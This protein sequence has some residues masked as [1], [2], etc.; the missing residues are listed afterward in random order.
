MKRTRRYQGV[1][2]YTG[3]MG[4]GKTYALAE[5]GDLM[6][7]RGRGVACN[8]GFDLK[9]A[10]VYRSFEEMCEAI[11]MGFVVLLDE[12]PL[13]FNARRWAEF[14]DSVWYGLT[15]ARHDGAEFHYSTLHEDFV[16]KVLRNLTFNW[17]DCRALSGRWLWR[18][19]YPPQEFRR[20]GA[21]PLERRLVRVR[22][23][24]AGLYD[25]TGKVAV[26]PRVGDRL[27]SRDGAVF[28]VPA[29]ATEGRERQV[30]N[31]VLVQDY[32]D[33]ESW[34][35]LVGSA[36]RSNGDGEGHR[37]PPSV[38]FERETDREADGGVGKSSIPDKWFG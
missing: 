26:P 3:M 19:R 1:T 7:R 27:S 11:A 5:Y 30:P 32:F 4:G 8:A 28:E 24:I 31:G 2:A 10:E 20:Q 21:R 13:Y 37:A 16:D 9:G 18:R 6:M 12:A 15:Q 29:G 38:G 14:P 22:S 36:V 23:R 34:R 35:E 25:T 17:W 33:N